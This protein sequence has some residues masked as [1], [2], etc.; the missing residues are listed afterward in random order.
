MKTMRVGVFGPILSGVAL[1]LFSLCGCGDDESDAGAATMDASAE[2]GLDAGPDSV[3][4]D[5]HEEA[6][7]SSQG[8]VVV[9]PDSAPLGETDT[10]TRFGITW[11]FDQK[12]PWGE[13]VNGDYWV[14]GPVQVV[15]MTPAPVDDEGTVRNGFEVNPDPGDHPYDSRAAGF[16]ASKVSALPLSLPAGS[17]LVST[18]SNP[19]DRDCDLT[20]QHPGFTN[21]Q[22]DCY[23]GVL[24]V[25]A[26]LTVLDSPPPQGSFRPFYVGK[27]KPLYS[28]LNLQDNLLPKLEPVGSPPSLP[29]LAE[30]LARVRLDHMPGWTAQQI[31]PIDSVGGYGSGMVRDIGVSGLALMID[32]PMTEKRELLIQLVQTGIDLFGTAKNGGVWYA[33]GGHGSGRK[34]PILFAGLMLD[35]AEILA[36]GTS[37]LGQ[38]QEDCQTYY[39]DDPSYPFYYGVLGMPRWGIRHCQDPQSTK[40][41]YHDESSGYRLCCNSQSWVAQSLTMRLLKMEEVWAHQAYFD[42]QDRFMQTESNGYWNSPWADAMWAAFRPT[43]DVCENGVRDRCSVLCDPDTSTVNG[44]KENDC[45]GD[46]PNACP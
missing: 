32:K 27:E 24:K 44:E 22:G 28:S 45:G 10:L 2:G 31:I 29:D 6:P 17:S 7:D 34:F 26:V 37:G 19:E 41:D 1:A 18:M 5:V 46:C 20:G 21:F 9:P 36:I 3:Q 25:A 11:T 15:S 16:D 38:F 8:D 43:I 42:Y 4:A 39:D 12:V 13:F 40:P 23:T 30:R 14:I 33:D 35:D